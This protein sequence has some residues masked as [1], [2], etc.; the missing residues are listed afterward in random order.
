MTIRQAQSAEDISTVRQLF[1]EYAQSLGFSLCFQ[2]FEQELAGLPG[3]YAEPRGRLLLAE[4]GGT[5]VGCIALH[6]FPQSDAAKHVGE[7]KRLYVRPSARGRRV[8]EQLLNHLMKEAKVIGYTHLWLDTV[9]SRMGRA[10][11]L[12][13]AN[14]F[15]EIAPYRANPQPGVIYMEYIVHS[16]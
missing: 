8:G 15:S 10:V 11:E 16:S 13:R 6:G 4:V 1:H 7:I 12:Y 9:P 3:E 5:A 2:S 14:G